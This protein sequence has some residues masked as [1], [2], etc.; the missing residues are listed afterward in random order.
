MLLTALDFNIVATA[1]PIISSEFN[2]YSNS[3]WLGNAFLITFALSQPIAAKLGDIFGRKNVFLF[4]TAIFLLGSAL[5]GWS[6][7]MDM[8]IWSRAVQGL[9]AGVLYVLTNVI[10]TDLVDLQEVGKF[11]SLTTLVW[12][13]ADVAGPLLGGA[14]SQYATWRWCFWINLF[15]C[16][17][18]FAIVL[19]TLR[20]PPSPT[21][22][23]SLGE[24]LKGFD[25]AGTIAI[26]GA[27][28]LINLGLTWGGHVFAWSDGKII[29][30][31]VGGG[32]LF[33]LFCIVEHFVKDPL[34]FPS[35]FRSRALLAVFTAEFFYGMVL[36][37]GMYY[38]PQYFQLV[39]G[40]TAILSG[41]GLLPMMLGLLVGNP[42]A[43]MV[44]SKKG[45]T[46]VNAIAGAALQVLATGLMT[47]WSASTSRAEAVLVPFVLGIGQG[48]CMSGMLM[49]AQVAVIPVQIGVVTALCFFIQAVGDSFGI[50]L[51]SAVY[52]N[53]LGAALAALGLAP[54]QVSDVL[55]DVHKVHTEFPADMV[56]RIIE[57]YA[58]SLQNGWW[59]LF[60][61]SL[62]CFI[63]CCAIRQHKFAA[64]TAPAKPALDS[65][66]KSGEV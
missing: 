49:S 4:G 35:M 59:F 29:G 27:T 58:H 8:L 11:L 25:Y 61:A 14:F 17:V 48:A 33:V 39:F 57:A 23:A 37:G 50:A 46:V 66:K 60:A 9:G 42:A 20:L 31:L 21:A 2:N 15:I 16:P 36:L 30:T 34:V 63:C 47:R 5:C 64:P 41:I 12:G 43:A 26:A 53:E 52:V 51:F 22:T 44:T 6:N 45:I 55:A 18:S 62:V 24:K 54:K 56:P 3:A 38:L 65:E 1:V 28:T 32:V 10:V 13:I 40:D 7:S 19:F